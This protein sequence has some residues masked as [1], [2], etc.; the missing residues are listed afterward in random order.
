MRKIEKVSYNDFME[1][2]NSLE[3]VEC[4]G[5]ID[6]CLLDDLLYIGNNKNGCEVVLLAIVKYLNEWS[7]C[8]TVK[9]AVTE[10]DKQKLYNQFN[11]M[12]DAQ[13]YYN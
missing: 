5:C 1:A 3:N 13:N 8:Y 10:N 11:D 4:L 6:G 2:V 12:E 7:S 9:I